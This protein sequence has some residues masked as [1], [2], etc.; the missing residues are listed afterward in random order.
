[1]LHCNH[2]LLGFFFLD[3]LTVCRFWTGWAWGGLVLPP[4]TSGIRGEREGGRGMNSVFVQ[5]LRREPS[6][7]EMQG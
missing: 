2:V 3:C 1:M 7:G 6:A 5:C 4:L